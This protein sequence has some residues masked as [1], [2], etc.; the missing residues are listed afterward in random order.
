[1]K[2]NLQ[3]NNFLIK[4]LIRLMQKQTNLDSQETMLIE[5]NI[6]RNYQ[7]SLTEDIQRIQNKYHLERR[8]FM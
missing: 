4:L 7:S 6:N 1:M 5:E 2:L 3:N 8:T